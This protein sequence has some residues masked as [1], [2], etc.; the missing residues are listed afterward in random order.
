M[1]T[2][3]TTA[4]PFRGHHAI[5]QR[6][7]LKSWT[8]LDPCVEVILFGDDEGAGETCRALG[9]RHEFH[10]ERNA[11]GTKRLDYMFRRAQE[12]A[13]HDLLC[14]IN[15]D[16]I[17][18][19]DFRVALRRVRTAHSYF[20]MVGRR[21][22][23]EIDAPLP[24]DRPEWS[25]RLR[26]SAVQHAKQRTAEWIDYFVFSRGVYRTGIPAFVVGRVFWDNWLVWK[27]QDTKFPVV[28]VSRAVIA[29]HQNHDY[30]YHPLGRAGVFHGVE[31]GRNYQ[32][33]GGWKH[34]RTIADATEVLREKGLR[35]NY[36]RHL[37]AAKRYLRQTGRLLQHDLWE[38]I[39]FLLLG[40]TR[41]LRQRMGLHARSAKPALGN[42]K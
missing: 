9:I 25:A 13:C 31:S 18:M 26:A 6:N 40:W 38:P 30:G 2:F 15:C 34:L 39:W 35:P 20:L 8:L 22:D 21:W 41:P 37:A 24:F 3:F 14:Y 42:Q 23:T 7:A 32:L 17:L 5:I 11:H 28:D 33:A 19:E 12:I 10:V 36:G 16:I 29:V 4:K 1:L 27:A